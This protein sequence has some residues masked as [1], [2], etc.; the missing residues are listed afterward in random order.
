MVIMQNIFEIARCALLEKID[1]NYPQMRD[2]ATHGLIDQ[3]CRYIN[4]CVWADN[5][6]QLPS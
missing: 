2:Q 4:R 3:I 6:V 1:Y 5:T